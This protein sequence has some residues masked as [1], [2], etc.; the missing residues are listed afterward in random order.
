[1]VK[2]EFKRVDIKTGYLCNNNCLFCVQA[3]NKDYANKN[4]D[5]I[6]KS[7]DSAKENGCTGV[8][9]TGGE[10][11]IRSDAIKLV[12]IARQKGFTEIQIQSN[13]R[14]FS[15]FEFCKKL[16]SAGVTEFSPALHG[17]TAEI[18]DYLTR[19]PDAFKNT[20]QGIR[21]IKRLGQYI[22]M[23][24]V[25]LKPNYRYAPHLSK[26][27]SEL[28]VDQFQYAFVHAMGNSK[29]NF[30]EMVPYKTLAIPYVKRGIDIAVKNNVK[31]MVEAVPFCLLVGYEKYVTE[32]YIPPTRIEERN[33]VIEDFKKSKEFSKKKF[34]QCKLCRYDDICEGPWREYP[35]KFGDSEF[36]PVPK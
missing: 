3:H 13:G 20:V 14:M 16:V 1:M 18:H 34:S 6:L 10:F 19:T 22:V 26:F 5:E 17:H 23:N 11:T 35:E 15:D 33:R 25:L 24:S 27:L 36:I 2:M 8:V 31:V 30:E 7:L 4:F 12:Q 29:E 21:N 9:F 32:L 28:K